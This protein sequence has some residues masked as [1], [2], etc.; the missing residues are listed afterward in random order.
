MKGNFKRIISVLIVFLMIVSLNADFIPASANAF[1]TV[2]KDTTLNWSQFLGNLELQGVSD[3]KTPRTSEEL[4]ENWRYYEDGG[5]EV[6][7]GTPIVVGDYVYCY[8]NEKI[9]KINSETGKVEASASAPGSAMF[10]IYACYGDGKIFVPRKNLETG[11]SNIIAYDADTL[12]QLFVTENIKT[13]ADL[14]TPV[15]YYKG[16][17][18][19]GTYGGNAVYGCYPTKDNDTTKAD[20]VVNATWTKTTK[21][22]VG[23]SW[24]GATFIGD[25][26]IFADNGIKRREGS[27]VYAVNYKTGEEI[28][29]FTLPKNAEVKSTIVYYEKNNRVYISAADNGHASIRSMEVNKNGTFNKES[30]K[31]YTS[32]TEGGGT[33]S[34]PVIYNDRLYLG[35]G[36]ATMG[37]AEPFHVIDANTLEEIYKID[38]IITKGSAAITT[39]YATKEN[40]QQVYIYMVPYAPDNDQAALYIIK[41]SVGQTAPD[42][43]KVLGVGTSQYCSQSIDIDKN[44]NLVFYNDAKILYSFGKKNKEN[45]II[46]GKDVFNQIDRLP[47]T[48]DFKYYNDFEIR[49]IKE[50]YD[51]L[52]SEEKAK[53]TNIQKLNDIL[54][55]SSENPIERMNKGI[56]S[57]PAIEDI[58]LEHE[59]KIQTLITGYNS[60]SDEEKSKIV[61]SDK[62]V[63]A[64]NK[65]VQLQQQ[66]QVDTIIKDIDNLPDKDKLTSDDKG[67]VDAIYSKIS[68]LDEELKSKITNIDKL[69]ATKQRIEDIIKQMNYANDLIKEKLDGVEIT[70]DSRSVILELDKVLEGLSES[71]IKKLNNYEYYLS[72]AKAKI[73]NLLIDKYVYID[74]KD[75]EVTSKNIDNLKS[76]IEEIKYYYNGVLN[77]DKKYIKNYDSAERV[78]NKISQ[79]EINNKGEDSNKGPNKLPTTGD[80]AGYTSLI[81]MI[82]SCGGIAVIK[83][84][85]K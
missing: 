22:T 60:L 68:N 36:G 39:A 58:T 4:K 16:Y 27:N 63:A 5:W 25:T 75:V 19:F 34:T 10:F 54:L 18:Y 50:R 9:L 42:Y 78:E 76:T 48:N 7:P 21:A 79:F 33:Q 29:R 11:V 51:N 59:Q 85:K 52:S 72:P 74:G 69:E 49:R 38:E 55:V 32:T 8:V 41:D 83:R 24:N 3:A 20:E 30:L 70:L 31:T 37:S 71:D 66:A 80:A 67:L 35:G 57:L 44:G 65:V 26:C 12:E 46:T 2:K 53:V 28:D 62:L 15:M 14:Q 1:K 56:E 13:K 17:I 84:I 61:G 43:E 40:N 81:T 82:L 64:Y 45:S 6:T 73:V 23:F 77:D 47:E